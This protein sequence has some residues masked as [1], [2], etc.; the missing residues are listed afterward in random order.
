M[1]YGYEDR[2]SVY[3]QFIPKK[4]FIQKRTRQ[5]ATVI[6][7]VSVFGFLLGCAAATSYMKF[8]SS[9]DRKQNFDERFYPFS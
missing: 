3:E 5:S 9:E 6:C 1:I 7:V 8:I 4:S 2:S